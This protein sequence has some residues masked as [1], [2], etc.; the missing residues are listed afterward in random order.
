[1]KDITLYKQIIQSQ[2]KQIDTLI[3]LLDEYRQRYIHLESTMNKI[4]DDINNQR[5]S[6]NMGS[7]NQKDLAD[8][9]TYVLK[10]LVDDDED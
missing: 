6:K 7:T 8:T 2:A 9:L 4:L 5:E 1:M 3:E 10:Y